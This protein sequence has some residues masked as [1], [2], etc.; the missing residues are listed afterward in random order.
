LVIAL[1]LVGCAAP[2]LMETDRSASTQANK[3]AEVAKAPAREAPRPAAAPGAPAGAAPAAPPQ[4]GETGATA[5]WDRMII[6]TANLTLVVQDVEQSLAAA[7]DITQAVGGF[8]AKSTTRYEGEHMVA[9]LTLQVPAVAYDNTI[10]RLRGLAVRVDSE[11]SS[12]QD[13]TE[14]YTDLESQLRN[15]Q[16]TEA[17]LLRLLDRA[18]QINDILAVQR[19]LTNVRG[20]IERIQGRMKYLSRRSDMS[21]INVSLIPEARSKRKPPEA[22][23][24][25]QTLAKALQGSLKLLEGLIDVLFVIIGYMWWL[26]ILA[27]IG[28]FIASRRLGKQRA[29]PV[30]SDQAKQ[31]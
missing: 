15:L 6:R 26:F 31:Q 17:S 20:Q 27:A 1:L 9:D 14:E 21:T 4:S 28:G 10:Q 3:A 13:V 24:P 23:N 29:K 2:A 19:E 12:S 7:R 11:S 30:A 8:L 25:L 5:A 18:T 16:A 22:W